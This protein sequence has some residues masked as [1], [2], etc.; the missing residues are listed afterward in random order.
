TREATM[1]DRAH[2]VEAHR[3]RWAGFWVWVGLVV[4]FYGLVAMLAY[5]VV[6][7]Y[8]WLTLPL[9]LLTGHVMHGHL[10]AYH[11]ASHGTLCPDRRL[12]EVCGIFVG[13]HALVPLALYRFVHYQHHVYLTSE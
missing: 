5:T 4:G 2:L 6:A 10:L 12:N 3:P 9:V 1:L 8:W 7:G 11:D 13:V